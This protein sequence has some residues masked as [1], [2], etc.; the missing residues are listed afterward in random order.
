M[1]LYLPEG[2]QAI[3]AS[4]ITEARHIIITDQPTIIVVDILL[5]KEDNKNSDGLELIK[6]IKKKNLSISIIVFSAYHEF[7]Y[8]AEALALGVAY[9]LT[10]PFKP[11]EFISAISSLTEEKA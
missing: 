4:T 9:F 11:N 1:K 7:G 3:N 10:K 6:W 5:N 8:E 2:Y